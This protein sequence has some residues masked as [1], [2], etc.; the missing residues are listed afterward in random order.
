MHETVKIPSTAGQSVVA[1]GGGTLSTRVLDNVLCPQDNLTLI[2]GWFP[3]D[4]W[5]GQRRRL[6]EELA[7][8]EQ[9]E[10]SQDQQEQG[11]GPIAG[12]KGK[13]QHAAEQ[14]EEQQ[15]KGD[16]VR[17]SKALSQAQKASSKQEG[18]EG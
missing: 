11:Q 8:Q 2:G 12:P 16:K 3:R 15:N 5:D 6:R 1:Q 18:A 9:E 7:T 10:Q 13:Q 17:I 14:R 4:D